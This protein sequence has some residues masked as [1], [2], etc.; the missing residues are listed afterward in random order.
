VDRLAGFEDPG[1]SRSDFIF[2]SWLV[3]PISLTIMLSSG[4]SPSSIKL[5]QGGGNERVRKSGDDDYSLWYSSDK[6]A[7]VQPMSL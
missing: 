5:G 3:A 4:W 2:K 1:L 7:V 6:R